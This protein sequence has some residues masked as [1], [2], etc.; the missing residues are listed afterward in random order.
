MNRAATIRLHCPR[1][2][3][4][5]GLLYT[6]GLAKPRKYKCKNCRDEYR[7]LAEQHPDGKVEVTWELRKTSL[8][9]PKELMS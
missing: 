3:K 7:I 4:G 2:N 5:A 1:C 9:I 6:A 8:P